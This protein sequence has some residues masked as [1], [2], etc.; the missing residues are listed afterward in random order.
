[1]EKRKRIQS[2]SPLTKSRP[3]EIHVKKSL[4]H[5][6]KNGDVHMVDVGEKDNSSRQA[7]ARGEIQMSGE[8]LS[9][10]VH[11]S[12]EKGDVLGTARLAGIMAAK[13]TSNLIPLCHPINL[14][15]VSIELEPIENEN[16]VEI[17][18]SVK[19]MQLLK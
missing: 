8:T 13:N 18:A 7:I 2:N 12:A 9:L 16:K 3:K 15:N 14:T 11:G 4:N 10:I 1:N 19:C 6:N 17:T 5:F